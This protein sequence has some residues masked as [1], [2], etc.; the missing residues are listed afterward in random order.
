MSTTQWWRRYT[1]PSTSPVPSG[2]WIQKNQRWNLQARI[3]DRSITPQWSDGNA[4]W[5]VRGMAFTAVRD[6]SSSGR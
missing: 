1:V 2:N 5:A 3:I 4:P 6:S